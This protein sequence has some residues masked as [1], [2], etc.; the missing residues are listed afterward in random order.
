MVAGQRHPIVRSRRV[1]CCRPE[2]LPLRLRPRCRTADVWELRYGDAA[3]AGK[4]LQRYVQTGERK[5][6]QLSDGG[7][8]IVKKPQRGIEVVFADRQCNLKRVGFRL[9][10]TTDAHYAFFALRTGDTGT[11]FFAALDSRKDCLSESN[12]SG[13]HA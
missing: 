12:R 4:A 7:L 13:V 5:A 3:Q 11:A 10:G 2:R 6:F 8:K 1:A 9:R